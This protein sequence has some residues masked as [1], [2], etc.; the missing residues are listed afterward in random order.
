MFNVS[1][2]IGTI[3]APAFCTTS[4]F[5]S[6]SM[7][8]LP[9]MS[10]TVNPPALSV[11]SDITRDFQVGQ[12]AAVAERQRAHNAAEREPIRAGFLRIADAAPLHDVEA[13]RL[14]VEHDGDLVVGRLPVSRSATA[15][16]RFAAPCAASTGRC[17]LRM[18]IP[19]ADARRHRPLFGGEQRYHGR[20]ARRRRA[21]PAP[22]P[23]A[24]RS[25]TERVEHVIA[26][27]RAIRRDR[28][29]IR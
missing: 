20:P 3:C 4:A 5:R 16:Q 15:A 1:L 2:V 17:R 26:E 29:S 11:P 9:T 24:I 23:T 21:R 8:W 19:F 22:P 28:W 18:R 14:T 10:G 13:A 7:N 12:A 27:C 25:A 6:R